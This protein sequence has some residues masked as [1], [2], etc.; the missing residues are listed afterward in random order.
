MLWIIQYYFFTK[1]YFLRQKNQLPIQ[2]I[3][4]Q[5]FVDTIIYENV[6]NIHDK[7][8]NSTF[9]DLNALIGG[10]FRPGGIYQ[11]RS[12]SGHLDSHVW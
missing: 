9:H 11:F 1:I 8:I 12:C 10:G 6:Q 3:K 2:I 7:P 4:D 5:I